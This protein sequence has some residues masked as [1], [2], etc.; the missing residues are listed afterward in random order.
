MKPRNPHSQSFS[1]KDLA[2]QFQGME[3]EFDDKATLFPVDV[4]KRSGQE[5]T[6][7]ARSARTKSS[8]NYPIR[9]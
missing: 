3:V 7:F 5:R 9:D 1:E 2:D 8:N 4:S 6:L